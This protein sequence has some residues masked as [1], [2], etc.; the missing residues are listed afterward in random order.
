MTSQHSELALTYAQ[1][2]LELADE[3]GELEPV[4]ADAAKLRE[5]AAET[6]NFH[7]FLRDPAI[8]ADERRTVIDRAFGDAH[9]LVLRF[10]HLMNDRDRLGRL[11]EVLDAFEHLLD[12][13]YGK[14]EADVTVAERLDEAQLAHV[15]DRVGRALGKE[16][17][18]HQ[19]VDPN[20]IGG[21]VLRVG[22][23]VVD[24]SVRRQLDAMR[25]RLS[26]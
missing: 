6:P 22:D 23:R 14:I 21:M 13:K 10:L 26:R 5:A 16:A 25:E 7:A 2:L 17:V 12:E 3:R 8:S 18:V 9:R 20:I 15:R 1:S 24:A 11:P 19:Y 4:A